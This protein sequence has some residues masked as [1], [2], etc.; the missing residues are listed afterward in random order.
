MLLDWLCTVFGVEGNRPR[1]F[2]LFVAGSCSCDSLD[3]PGVQAQVLQGFLDRLMDFGTA[4][5]DDWSCWKDLEG[6]DWRCDCSDA[7][8]RYV[9]PEQKFNGNEFEV[10]KRMVEAME[11]LKAIEKT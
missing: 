6:V 2:Y 1:H 9:G 7:F 8:L 10:H 5:G 4:V 11:R 3:K